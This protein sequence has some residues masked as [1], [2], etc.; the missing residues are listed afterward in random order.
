VKNTF[1]ILLEKDAIREVITQLFICTDNR[2]WQKVKQCFAENVHF[3]MTSMAGGE[4]TMMK[5]QEI[6]DAWESGLKNL[7]AIHHQAGNYLIEVKENQADAFCYAIASHYLRNK[8]NQNTRTFVGSYD[9]HLVK[10]STGWRIDKF[11]FN[12]KY[13]DGNPNLEE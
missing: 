12:L 5:A 10:N 9:F 8:A 6:V 13:M 7:Q 11:K 4:P 2:D 3:D 1:E